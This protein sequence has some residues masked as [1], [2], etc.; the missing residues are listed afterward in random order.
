MQGRNTLPKNAAST[1]YIGI[2]ID[3]EELMVEEE[4]VRDEYVI[5]VETQEMDDTEIHKDTLILEETTQLFE[6]NA[7]IRRLEEELLQSQQTLTQNRGE[8][9]TITWQF[10]EHSTIMNRMEVELA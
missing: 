8:L 10:Q 4:I 6:Q 9:L 1:T 2:Q 5:P 3:P 7:T